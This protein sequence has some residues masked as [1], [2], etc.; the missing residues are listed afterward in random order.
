M[1][2]PLGLT[3]VPSRWSSLD[4]LASSTA[5]DSMLS[6]SCALSVVSKTASLSPTL[7]AGTAVAD[8]EVEA[9]GPSE[10]SGR[11]LESEAA[12][13]E[14]A[15]EA[16]LV[17]ASPDAVPFRAAIV[18]SGNDVIARRACKGRSSTSHTTTLRQ[19]EKLHCCTSLHDE[20]LAAC[21]SSPK[22]V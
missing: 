1:P 8:F 7:G 5:I 19:D 10:A 9:I 11:L 16:G 20:S 18:S 6:S 15:T 3:E 22:H 13:D 2:T 17:A 12:P 4:S 21:L 14:L